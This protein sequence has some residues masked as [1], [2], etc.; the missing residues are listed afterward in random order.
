MGKK[1]KCSEDLLKSGCKKKNSG[2]SESNR[3]KKKND[4]LLDQ[5]QL[6]ILKKGE[7]IE[8]LLNKVRDYDVYLTGL[9]KRCYIFDK[10]YLSPFV[11]NLSDYQRFKFFSVEKENL[12]GE[13]S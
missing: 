4:E 11:V 9:Q 7:A 1:R 13:L 12:D 2:L 6:K 10:T 8:S 3:N 5:N